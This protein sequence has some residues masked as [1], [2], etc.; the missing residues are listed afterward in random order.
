MNA[1]DFFGAKLQFEMDACDLNK[2]LKK[3][4]SKYV[5][6]DTRSERAYKMEHIKGAINLPNGLMNE[7]SVKNFDKE[8]TYVTYC[9]GF[10]C[11]A[12]TKGAYKLSKLGFKVIELIGGIDAWKYERHPT[13][14]SL[15]RAEYEK[16]ASCGP[17]CSC[18]N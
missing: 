5:I 2:E 13:E 17:S 9:D 15:S 10:G 6:V 1:V 16:E 18:H 14:T 12:S 3:D 7:E 11:N 8:K 4:E